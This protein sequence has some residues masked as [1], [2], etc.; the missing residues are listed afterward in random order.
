MIEWWA[1]FLQGGRRVALSRRGVPVR[2]GG[3]SRGAEAGARSGG[4]GT[5]GG[6]MG[7][8]GVAGGVWPGVRWRCGYEGIWR[9]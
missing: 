1:P 9:E 3:I 4:I 8:G 2:G 6:G 5:R 7:V